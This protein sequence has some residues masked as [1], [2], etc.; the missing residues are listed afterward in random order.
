MKT[1]GEDKN[2]LINT[3]LVCP[4][5]GPPEPSLNCLFIINGEKTETKTKQKKTGN[6]LRPL[7]E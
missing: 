1:K 5:H 4:S 7:G 2:L 3:E 6:N